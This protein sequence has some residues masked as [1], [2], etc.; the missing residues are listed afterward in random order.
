MQYYIL[1]KKS[2]VHVLNIHPSRINYRAENI[3][4]FQTFLLSSLHPI[5][6]WRNVNIDEFGPTC[7]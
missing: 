3:S 5:P 4:I 1:A 6:N 7:E 2:G